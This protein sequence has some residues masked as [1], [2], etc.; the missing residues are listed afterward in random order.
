MESRPSVQLNFLELNFLDPC[1][2]AAKTI[3]G[4]RPENHLK[5]EISLLAATKLGTTSLSLIHFGQ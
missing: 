4:V 3:V 5:A 2:D 1:Q